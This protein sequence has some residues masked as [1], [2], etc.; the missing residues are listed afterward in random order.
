ML[1]NFANN[2][3]SE[4]AHDDNDSIEG[5]YIK[6]Q[7]NRITLRKQ[8]YKGYSK[9]LTSTRITLEYNVSYT[10]KVKVKNNTITVYRND[11][12]VFSYTDDIAYVSG[13]T[14]F[15]T[16]GFNATYSNVKYIID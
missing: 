1:K 11:E 9:D 12:E 2:F 6:I 3:R 16:T 7:R 4:S 10:Y 8:C 14:G 15:Y 5:Y 13:K